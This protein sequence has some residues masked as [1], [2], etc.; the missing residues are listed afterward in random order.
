[1]PKIGDKLYPKDNSYSKCLSLP[2]SL[3]RLLLAGTH[4]QPAVLVTII[5]EPILITV[6]DFIPEGKQYEFVIVEHNNKQ[7]LI[8]NR[9]FENENEKDYQNNRT[10]LKLHII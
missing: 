2:Y 9:F 10:I 4:K 6:Y 5:S 1:M 7:Y 3:P 8:L